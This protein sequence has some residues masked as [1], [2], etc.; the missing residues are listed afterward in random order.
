MGCEIYF[1]PEAKSE[2]YELTGP[3][4]TRV[5]TEIQKLMHKPTEYGIHPGKESG[6]NNE[7]FYCINVL[8]YQIHYWFD[9]ERIIIL[10]VTDIRSSS[11]LNA[12]NPA[13][14]IQQYQTEAMNEVRKIET[15]LAN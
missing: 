12:L 9:G 1:V 4:A 3:D 13:D 7:N 6:L 2:L 15:L 5:L 8:S 14:R 11:G 10:E